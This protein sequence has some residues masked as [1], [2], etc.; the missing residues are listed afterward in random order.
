[1]RAILGSGDQPITLTERDGE[2]KTIKEDT[3]PVTAVWFAL[4][5]GKFRVRLHVEDHPTVSRWGDVLDDDDN[6]IGSAS[7]FIYGGRGFAIHTK[8]YGGFVPS[9]NI[10]FV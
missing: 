4:M 8:A 7:D 6:V 3:N 5:G 1:M 10:D 9:E 2:M